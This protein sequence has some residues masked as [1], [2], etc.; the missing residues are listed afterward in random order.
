MAIRK[1]MQVGCGIENLAEVPGTG[2]HSN[3]AE[4]IVMCQRHDINYSH[5][6]SF[7][8]V[9]HP[10]EWILSLYTYIK[11]YKNHGLNKKVSALSFS[12]FLEQYADIEEK[13]N[14]TRPFAT[15][16]IQSQTKFLCD[17]D[18]K[19]L[20]NFVAKKENFNADMK[21]ICSKIGIEYANPGIINS[22]HHVRDNKTWKDFY[23][24][25][26]KIIVRRLFEKDFE[27]FKYVK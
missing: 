26:D 12:G 7:A 11:T 21:I 15:N 2:G 20:V 13:W 9:R 27:I 22:L 5:Y 1:S 24:E 14:Q 19:L 23:T 8:M 3:A 18:N 25:N 10:Y 17:S 16:K 4:T 6:F